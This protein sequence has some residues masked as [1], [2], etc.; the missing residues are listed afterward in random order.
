MTD[1][2]TIRT[3][4]RDECLARKPFWIGGVPTRLDI[5]AVSKAIAARLKVSLSDVDAALAEDGPIMVT[6]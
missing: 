2:A 6:K 4:H 3:A 5:Y 1:A